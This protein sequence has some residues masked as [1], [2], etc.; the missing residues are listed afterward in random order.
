MKLAERDKNHILTI[1]T[2]NYQILRMKLA[3]EKRLLR[4]IQN[5]N[6][7]ERQWEELYYRFLRDK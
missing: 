3:R 7:T 6:C 1:L 4:D 5:G 2:S